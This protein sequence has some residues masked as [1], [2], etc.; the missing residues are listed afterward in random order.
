MKRSRTIPAKVLTL[1]DRRAYG[2]LAPPCEVLSPAHD[3]RS[4][5]EYHH[6]RMF[7]RGG[8]HTA[9]NLVAACDECH[10]FI[11]S[12]VRWS[13]KRDLLLLSNPR[14][15]WRRT[16]AMMKAARLDYEEEAA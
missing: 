15:Y 5:I 4:R 12:N 3:P 16:E 1:V 10:K 8:S 6:R 14:R 13:I 2:A 11:H 9:A 7:S